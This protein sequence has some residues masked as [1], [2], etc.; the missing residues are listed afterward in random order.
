MTF[1]LAQLRTFTSIAR[2]GSFNAAARELRLTQP[3]VS[4]RIRE[5]E[6][7]LATELF[8]RNGPRVSLTPE[9]KALVNDAERLLGDADAI[10]A[11][12]H[13]R[14]PLKGVLRLGLNESFALVCLTDLLQQLE[15]QHPQ[16][17]TSVHVGDTEAVSRLLNERALDVAI[18]SQPDL[19]QHVRAIPIGTNE[20]GWIAARGL[21]TPPAPLS[22][23]ALARFHLTIGPPSA[24][25]HGTAMTWF[26]RAGV[27]PPRVSTCN[28]LHVTMLSVLA[29]LTI[30]LMPVRVIQA[31]LE[32]DEAVLLH[33]TPPIG[34]HR[35][36]LCH[37]ASESGPGLEQVLSLIRELVSAKQLFTT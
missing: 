13:S 23:A 27:I 6:A 20:M 12:F 9:G 2:L 33:V 16:L 15:A 36:F 26:A 29:G 3:S 37:Q 5:L 25:L 32:R 21:P 19:E 35:V 31:E 17:K 8:V 11:R 14:D 34:G 18:V 28:S 10:M 1:S 22:P 4:L 30:G 24:R 7:A